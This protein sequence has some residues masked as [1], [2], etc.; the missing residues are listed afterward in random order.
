MTESR[1]DALVAEVEE[2][3]PEPDTCEALVA[4]QA[5][6][7]PL[8]EG[9]R[10]RLKA[11]RG[12]GRAAIGPGGAVRNTRVNRLVKVGS[13]LASLA[14]AFSLIS[15]E[16]AHADIII[17][18]DM[19]LKNANSGKCL[20]TYGGG[21]NNGTPAIQWSCNANNDQ[22][23]MLVDVGTG[24]EIENQNAMCLEAPGWTTAPG[25]QLGQWSCNGGANQVWTT[26]FDD[27]GG[28]IRIQ[29]KN[30]NLCISA[31]GGSMADGAP[32]IQWYCNTATDQLWHKGL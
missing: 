24:Y 26:V 19:H 29:N 3:N 4:T 7:S 22:S 8:R 17:T 31:Q 9:A 16:S 2:L 25:A 13:T 20:G 12:G 28:N 14:L 27:G 23:W 21:G 11:R 18:L 5:Q 10:G 1:I 30:S 15:A 6:F 32:I